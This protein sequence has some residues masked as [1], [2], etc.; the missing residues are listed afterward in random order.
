MEQ[1]RWLHGPLVVRA[2]I[3]AD[4]PEVRLALPDRPGDAPTGAQFR[5]Q[6]LGLARDARE[7]AIRRE[8]TRG[9]VPDFLRK[10]TPLRVTATDPAGAA[11]VATY[12]VT[13]DYLAVGRDD[14]FFRVPMSPG[15]ALAVADAARCSLITTKISDDVFAA[16]PVKLEPRPLTKSRDAAATFFEHHQIIEDQLRGKP[17]GQLVAGIK[18]DVVW[19][20]RLRDKPHRVALYGWHYRDGRPIQSLY[21]GH[22]DWYV[23]YSHGIRLMSDQVRVEN[24]WLKTSQVLQ[25][26]R[27]HVLLSREGPLD[28]AAL[29]KSAEW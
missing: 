26:P 5:D 17:R 23:D 19:T 21:V 15:T 6:V 3:P 24:R 10:L 8:I 13:C 28:P 18:K 29:R 16:A 1:V 27:L 14:D 20:N 11:L 9:N 12:F 2:V 7:A 4:A 22:V 25:D